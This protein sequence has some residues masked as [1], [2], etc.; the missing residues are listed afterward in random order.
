MNLYYTNDGKRITTYRE[1]SD[2]DWKYDLDFTVLKNRIVQLKKDGYK[3]IEIKIYD[4]Y[5][6][7]VATEKEV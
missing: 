5:Y 2:K 4:S 3:S 6:G 7:I 1:F